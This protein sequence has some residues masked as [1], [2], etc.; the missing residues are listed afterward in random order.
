[1]YSLR[2]SALRLLL[3]SSAGCMDAP[4]LCLGRVLEGSAVVI[5]GVTSPLVWV[6]TMVTLLYNPTYSYP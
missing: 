1:M 6:I 5:S 3:L 2:G 4:D